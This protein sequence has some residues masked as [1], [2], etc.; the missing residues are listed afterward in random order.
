LSA[1]ADLLPDF[2]R[3]TDKSFMAARLQLIGR[4]K[5]FVIERT[6]EASPMLKA[7]FDQLRVE[8][9][10]TVVT[11]NYDDLM[12]RTGDWYD[13]FNQP[14]APDRFGT[15]DFS[16]FPRK[17]VERPAVLVH[18]HGSVRFN[19]TPWRLRKGDNVRH[20]APVRGLGSTLYPPSGI[21]QPVPIVASDGKNQWMTRACVPFGYYYNA[22]VNA[23]PVKLACHGWRRRCTS[24]HGS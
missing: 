1:F 17:S 16:G 19:L 15:F 13:G 3:V 22:F 8:F 7:F 14:V 9:D 23:M 20:I 21:V 24:P 10:L 6:A 5:D 12:D 18:L 2:V 4:I 11:L